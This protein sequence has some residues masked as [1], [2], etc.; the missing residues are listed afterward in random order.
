MTTSNT[1]ILP[2]P[3]LGVPRQLRPVQVLP[4]G[5][6]HGDRRLLLGRRR[7]AAA[8]PGSLSVDERP[9]AVSQPLPAGEAQVSVNYDTQSAPGQSH[10][11]H[12]DT[13]CEDFV[14]FSLVR[15]DLDLFVQMF[16]GTEKE[17]LFLNVLKGRSRRILMM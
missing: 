1:S 5:G 9:A 13:G 8:V 12:I 4:A 6:E 15:T 17:Y 16:K 2:P 3:G 7:H 10:E 14:T 11:S